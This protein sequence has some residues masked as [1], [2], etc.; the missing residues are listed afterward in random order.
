MPT[1]YSQEEFWKLYKKLPQELKDA[2]SSMET[3]R[4]IETI[5]ERSGIIDQR[6]GQ[7]ADMIGQ[8]LVGLLQPSEFRDIL[9]K[10]LR[11]SDEKTQQIT[12]E[13]NRFIFYPVKPELEQLYGAIKVEGTSQEGEDN[14]S[15][16]QGT[17]QEK[18]FGASSAQ[19]FDE[20][21][22]ESPEVI[23][24]DGDPESTKKADPYRESLE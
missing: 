24:K 10:E 13:V 11:L 4:A 12:R 7:I 14:R 9:R 2:I 6:V 19:P 1:P 8:V 23:E 22:P 16:P 15:V 17:L 21:K 3:T 18:P 20:G 5:S